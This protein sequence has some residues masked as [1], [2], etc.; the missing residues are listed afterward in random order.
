MQFNE[1]QRRLHNCH[2]DRETKFLL[3]HMFEVQIE[4]SRQL[5][6]AAGLIQA[7]VGTVQNFAALHEST[8][9][10]VK[11]LMEFGRVDGV[12]VHSVVNDPEDDK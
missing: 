12:E 5:D 8:Q 11:Q 6:T 1:F 4:F 2:L 9:N 10:K 7:L 3:T